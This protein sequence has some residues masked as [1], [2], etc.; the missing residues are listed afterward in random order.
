MMPY[1]LAGGIVIAGG[2][3]FMIARGYMSGNQTIPAEALV[4]LAKMK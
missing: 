2:A 1:L 4:A 3:V